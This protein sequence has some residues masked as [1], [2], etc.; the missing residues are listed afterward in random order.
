MDAA[1]SR[2]ASTTSPVPAHPARPQLV[3]RGGARGDRRRPA[4]LVRRAGSRASGS[5]SATRSSRTASCATTPSR[6]RTTTRTIR[7]RGLKQVYSMNRPELHDVLRRWR[8]LAG[9]QD[10]E[11]ILVG[12]TYVLDLEQL[13]PFYGNG[14]DELHLAFNFLFVHSDLDAAPSCAPIVEGVEAMLP[15]DVVAGLDGLQPRRQ[16]ARVRAGRAATRRA[17]R[18]ALLILLG[19]RGTPF[20]YYGDEIGLPDADARPGRRRSTRCRTARATPTRTATSAARRCSGRAEPGGRLHDRRRGPV[21]AVRRPGGRQRRRPARGPRLDA[22]PRPRPD[23]AAARARRPAR[24]RVRDAARAGRRV[25][26]A[27]RRRHGGRA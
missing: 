13:I 20:L 14:Q 9:R 21:A 27:A 1:T 6:P 17:A 12:E 3:E 2:P 23:R 5:T 10:P 24:R 25:G 18:A 8:A 15:A 22:A 7:A 26:V 11:R 4:V 16:A 19:L